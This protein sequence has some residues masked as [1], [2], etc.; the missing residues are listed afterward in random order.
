MD[1]KIEKVIGCCVFKSEGDGCLTAKWANKGGIFIE[2]SKRKSVSNGDDPFCGLF[3]TT[4]I[5]GESIEKAELKIEKKA[6][7]LYELNWHRGTATMFRGI[8]MLYE[9]N[10]VVAYWDL[11]IG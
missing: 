2:C 9:N 11:T 5:E 4:W 7:G 3:Q 8:G 6:S 10:L 1:N